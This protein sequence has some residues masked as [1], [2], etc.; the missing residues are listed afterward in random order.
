MINLVI[1]IWMATSFLFAAKIIGAIVGV[2]MSVPLG[3]YPADT[4]PKQP[5]VQ[6]RHAPERTDF[7]WLYAED[8]KGDPG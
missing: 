2:L 4:R 6:S 8:D 3:S 7:L 1:R 5:R